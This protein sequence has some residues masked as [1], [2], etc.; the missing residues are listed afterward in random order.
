[1]DSSSE[2]DPTSYSK[3]KEFV[4]DLAETL[5]LRPN[6]SR[7][8]VVP[9]SSYPREAIRFDVFSTPESL[10]SGLDG[11]V[12]FGGKRR[13]DLALESAARLLTGEKRPVPKI[14]VLLTAGK[15][16]QERDTKTLDTAVRPL[17]T[18]GARTVVI[19]LGAKPD[20]SELSSVADR[21]DDVIPIPTFDELIP[22]T[23]AVGRRIMD[24]KGTYPVCILFCS[25]LL[26]FYFTV[27]VKLSSYI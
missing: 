27:L 10:R 8:A 26:L 2:V 17:R 12:Y 14:V 7:V 16:S 11:L 18:L 22:W 13:I 4:A 9:Y 21:H 3:E 20:I 6:K 5:N 24:S 25:F 23:Q 15:Q 19:A 1:M